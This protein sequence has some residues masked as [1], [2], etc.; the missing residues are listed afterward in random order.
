M[1]DGSGTE[2]KDISRGGNQ[3]PDRGRKNFDRRKV[4][5]FNCDKFGLILMS[6]RTTTQARKLRRVMT[7]T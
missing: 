5:C 4:Q 6:G 7:N 2:Q 3:Y 1:N